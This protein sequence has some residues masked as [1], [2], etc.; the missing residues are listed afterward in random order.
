MG[1][2]DF[3]G[4]LFKCRTD[5]TYEYLAVV[6]LTSLDTTQADISADVLVAE[7]YIPH[8]LNNQAELTSCYLV[9]DNT[10]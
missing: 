10:T 9:V 7:N 3:E 5:G 4:N 2:I 6:N 1:E 8:P